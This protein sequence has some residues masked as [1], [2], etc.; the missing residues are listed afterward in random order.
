MKEFSEMDGLSY[1]KAHEVMNECWVHG[2]RGL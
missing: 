2:M 1:L